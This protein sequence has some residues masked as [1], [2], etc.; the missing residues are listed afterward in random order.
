MSPLDE[1]QRVINLQK[2][3]NVMDQIHDVMRDTENH[4]ESIEQLMLRLPRAWIL[5][6]G[7]IALMEQQSAREELP[8][9]TL[10]LGLHDRALKR[11]ARRWLQREIDFQ[12]RMHF[13]HLCCGNH[14]LLQPLIDEDEQDSEADFSIDEDDLPF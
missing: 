2:V 7:A 6:A 12:L 9:P 4:A 1:V 13:E 5:L 10:V 11:L 14:P 8:D 3:D